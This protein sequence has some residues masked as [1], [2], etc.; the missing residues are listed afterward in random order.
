MRIFHGTQTPGLASGIS[1][2]TRYQVS[3]DLDELLDC[4]SP[5]KEIFSHALSSQSALDHF[6]E[7]P[8]LCWEI[9]IVEFSRD[10]SPTG[11]KLTPCAKPPAPALF[12]TMIASTF[13]PG[14]SC[15]ATSNM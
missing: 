10:D 1:N 11:S 8:A 3:S 6:P 15:C 2:F 12:L 14:L 7:M 4:A 13:L 9:S 5:F